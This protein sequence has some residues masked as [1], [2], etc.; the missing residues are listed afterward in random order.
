MGRRGSLLWI[1]DDGLREEEDFSWGL[2][3]RVLWPALDPGGLLPPCS[4]VGC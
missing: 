1:E 2:L 4:L 3:L